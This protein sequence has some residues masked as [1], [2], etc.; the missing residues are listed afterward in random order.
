MAEGPDPNDK[1]LKELE[2][3]ITCAVCCGHYQE[4]KLLPC[5]HYYCRACIETLA[6]HS[7]GRPFPCPE[8]RRDTTLPSGGVEQLQSAFFVERMKDVYQ[9]MA[10]VEGKVEAMCESCLKKGKAVAFCRQCTAF[11][12]VPCVEHHRML[13]V[14]EGHKVESLD[15]LKRGGAKHVP[16]KETPPP[17][18]LEHDQIRK[19][20][21][22]DCKCLICGDCT[23][24]DHNGHSYNFLKKCATEAHKTL[25]DSLTPLQRVQ[26]NIA[27]ANKKL[28]GT[29][30][31]VGSQEEEV[32]KSVEQSF[33]QLIA[34]LEQ[35]KTELVKKV[36]TLAK[37]KKDALTAQ[38][39]GLEM[40]Q[41]EIQSLV[42]FVERNVE[43]TSDQDLMSILTQ[44]Q[45]K[46][47]EGEKRHEQLSLDPA[48][49]ADLA[50]HSPSI[51]A[52]PRDLGEVFQQ[53]IPAI[54]GEIEST[55]QL[56]ETMQVTI[57]APTAQSADIHAQLQS[58]A[59]PASS[60]QADVVGKGA[61]IYHI[62]YTP[63]VRGRHDLKVKVSGQNIA[64]SPF[65][66]FVKIYP[67]QLGPPVRTITGVNQ[68]WAIAITSKQQLVVT[69]DGEKITVRERDGKTIRTVENEKMRGPRGVATGPDG[70]IYVTDVSAHCLFKFDKDGRLLKTLQNEFQKPYFIK[71]INNRLYVS[72][73]G[74]NVVK[75]LDLDFNV[76]GTIPT[77]E[78]P[79]P[80]DIAEGND[81]LYVVGGG[82]EGKIGVYTCAPN[83]EFRRHLN[84]QPFSV[85][86]SYPRGI[87]FDCSGHLFVTHGVHGV[88]CV[89]VFKP[90]GE[91]V[92]TLGQASSGVRM[93][94]PA[95]IAIDEDGFVYVCDWDS[96]KNVVVVF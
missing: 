33:D 34:I 3:D 4:A 17:N 14:F 58:L 45:S 93:G 8:C 81:G 50:Y 61:G 19:I 9:K 11:L 95:G 75:I 76:I 83:G 78:C 66:V 16:L 90:S 40:S 31:Q 10:K 38:M 36:R 72:D 94:W 48:T 21:C 54:L 92:A 47:K 69:E 57:A 64:G 46:V 26:A 7:R 29:K 79:N 89:Y 23:L 30:T 67:T 42:E 65:R 18:C 37:E 63:R 52:I 91:H 53:T 6:K 55:C 56:G 62:T 15:D 96:S 25:H 82:V 5:N 35:R 59:D 1:T 41:T 20:F 68:P 60:V 44:L 88:Q 51:K 12:C 84:I 39:K 13:R 32:C 2:K 77:K 27:G 71:S 24:I 22:F 70:A 73:C 85:T 87:C 43:N 86:L 49:T 28:A 74:K 80:F